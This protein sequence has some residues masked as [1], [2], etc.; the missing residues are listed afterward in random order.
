VVSE[1]QTKEPFAVV[2]GVVINGDTQWKSFEA[3]LVDMRKDFSQLLEDTELK[4]HDLFWG[5]RAFQQWERER[6]VTFQKEL[7]K[8]IAR[9]RL[10]IHA[11]F[12][13]RDFFNGL[14]PSFGI[15]PEDQALVMCL[16]TIETWFC[17]NALVKSEL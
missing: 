2:A 13:E 9:H 17:G 12:V 4:A 15:K 5:R 7:L 14:F 16:S 6:R 1:I 8:L 10:P 11:A 3:D